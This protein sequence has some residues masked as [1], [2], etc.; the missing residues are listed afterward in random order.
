[1]FAWKL[2]LL[3]YRLVV[4]K[5]I[6]FCIALY[7]KID[8]LILIGYFYQD[9][10]LS[11]WKFCHVKVYHVEVSQFKT[12]FRFYEKVCWGISE[13]I[14]FLVKLPNDT[15]FFITWKFYNLTIFFS[16][17]RKFVEVYR[18]KL[19]IH[20]VLY[21][22]F[23]PGC[24]AFLVKLPRISN[25]FQFHSRYSKLTKNPW[26]YHV[27]VLQYNFFS[28][29]R[30]SLLRNIRMAS[31]PC[32]ITT[33]LCIF[34]GFLAIFKVSTSTTTWKF[35]N[36]R[37]FSFLYAKVCRGIS[38][39]IAYRWYQICIQIRRFFGRKGDKYKKK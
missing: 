4:F 18:C 14:A 21:S 27:K 5:S 24:P 3:I 12:F 37:I 26:F 29:L 23:S 19:N 32:Q 16:F 28:F 13:W 30:E 2:F 25:Y 33:F 22:V 10:Q 15:A 39:Q 35:C 17:T 38:P 8:I 36:L 31:F 6:Q 34:T 11:L 1:M 20:I 9:G 7:S